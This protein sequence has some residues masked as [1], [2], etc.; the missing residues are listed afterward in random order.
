CIRQ[1]PEWRIRSP[2]TAASGL[3]RRSLRG[4]LRIRTRA[5]RRSVRSPFALGFAQQPRS[6]LKIGGLRLLFVVFGLG[7]N[8]RPEWLINPARTILARGRHEAGVNLEI[9][10]FRRGNDGCFVGNKRG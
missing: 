1:E 6:R 9:A 10:V 5:L 3:R 2:A 7:E 8:L 4:R